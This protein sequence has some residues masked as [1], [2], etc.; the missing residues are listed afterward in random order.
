MCPSYSVQLRMDLLLTIMSTSL[1]ACTTVAGFL[2]ELAIRLAISQSTCAEL[3]L[4]SIV[5]KKPQRYTM[6][7]P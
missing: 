1:A 3:K 4:D 7:W 5:H 6:A 2:G